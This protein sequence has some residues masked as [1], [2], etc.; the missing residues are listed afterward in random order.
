MLELR[1]VL[2]GRG[3]LRERPGQHEL[4]LEH[5]PAA[6]DDAVEGRPHPPE[7]RVPHAML[8]AFD[9]LPGIALEPMSVE[10][11]QALRL[12]PAAQHL[13]RSKVGHADCTVTKLPARTIWVLLNFE[14]AER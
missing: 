13:V 12:Y 5:H 4:G 3:L 10:G 7:H 6:R 9:G 1:H 8:D 11:P 14:I 2:P